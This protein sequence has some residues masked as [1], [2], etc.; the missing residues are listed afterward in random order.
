MDADAI[1]IVCVI[2]YVTLL[3]II[4]C[5]WFRVTQAPYGETYRRARRQGG[6]Q[7]YPPDSEEPAPKD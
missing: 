5:I 2:F 7:L 3:V 1:K 4:A 6:Y